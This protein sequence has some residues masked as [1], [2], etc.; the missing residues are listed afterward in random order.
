MIHRLNRTEYANAIRD[1]LALDIGDVTT[2]LPADDSSYG[3]DNIA[4]VLGVS[5]LLQERYLAAADRISALAVGDTEITPGSDTFRVRQDVSQDGHIEGLP[6]GTVG[7]LVVHYTFPLDGEY[8]FEVKLYRNNQNATKGIDYV[9]QFEI[10]V[11]GQRVHLAS[12][13]GNEDLTEYYDKVI[14]TSDAVDARL[15]VRVPVRGGPAHGDRGLFGETSGR[16]HQA[17]G[18]VSAHQHR[19][20]GSH[21]KAAHRN[22]GDR[23][24]VQPDRA[25]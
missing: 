11:D 2:L 5:P 20:A 19:R 3:F 23:R 24:S 16:G 9:N 22:P 17:P 12:L 21:G 14:A 18:A 15:R 8:T 7:G 13:G 25:W 6:L 1:L 4:D 10:A